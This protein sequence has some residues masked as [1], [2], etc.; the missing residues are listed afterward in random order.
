MSAVNND[1]APSTEGDQDPVSVTKAS[2]DDDEL[3]RAMERANPHPPPHHNSFV[4]SDGT[5]K[6]ITPP[7]N[8]KVNQ[9]YP[10]IDS[11]ISLRQNDIKY[12]EVLET[13]KS[14]LQ[15]GTK[16]LIDVP[17]PNEENAEQSVVSTDSV[18]RSATSETGEASKDYESVPGDSTSEKVR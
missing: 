3:Q 1:G 7:G 15:L 13:I 11:D 8:V 14:K 12:G 6:A 18:E 5:M 9:F 17:N 10:D 4:N 16:E 2:D